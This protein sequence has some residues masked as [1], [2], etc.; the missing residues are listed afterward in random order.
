MN[1]GTINSK[2][3]LPIK[4]FAN[5]NHYFVLVNL[6]IA[7]W[8]LVPNAG[9]YEITLGW[10]PSTS[11]DVA[12][13]Y[14]HYGTSSREYTARIDAGLNATSVISGLQ[15]GLTYYFAATS[16]DH[17]GMQSKLSNEVS[18]FIPI[19]GQP[20]P[21]IT[22][23]RTPT[24]TRTPT[25]TAT[26]TDTPG[27]VDL[28][29]NL[30]GHWKL[31]EGTGLSAGD[32]SPWR[33]HGI[34]VN[35][36][37]WTRG[38]IH[39]GLSFDGIDDYVTFGNSTFNLTTQMSVCFWIGNVEPTDKSEQVILARGQY[40]YPFQIKYRNSNRTLSVTIRTNTN[41]YLY[42]SPLPQGTY[43]HV[44]VTYDGNQG[45]IYL[46][47][48]LD[49]VGT[50]T[51]ILG[52]GRETNVTT[53]GGWMA[54]NSFKGTIDDLRIYSRAINREEIQ[55][56]IRIANSGPTPLPTL[57]GISTPS[58]TP[59]RT[60]TPT[61]TA[62]PTSSP[63]TTPGSTATAGTTEDVLEGLV[64]HWRLDEG[65]GSTAQDS[66]SLR[67]H[68]TLVNGPQWTTG[69]IGGGLRFDGID[70]YVDLG[71][72]NLNLSSALSICFW[73]GNTR[74][75]ADSHQTLL[76]R[77][78]DAYPISIRLLYESRT[79]VAVIRT[80][81]VITLSSNPVSPFS[82][83]HVA[84]TYDG[85]QIRIYINGVLD[86]STGQTGKLH[87]GSSDY[88]TTLG[89]WMSQN[90]FKGVL[91]D[92][93][94][95]NRSLSSVEIQRLV[96]LANPTPTPTATVTPSP[97]PTPTV[98]NLFTGLV[99]HWELDEN[100]GVIAKDASPLENHGTLVNEPQWTVGKIGGRLRFDGIND[101][102]DLGDSTFDLSSQLSI[103]FWI[104]NVQQTTAPH[105][106]VLTRGADSYPFQ[107]RL[108]NDLRAVEVTVRTAETVK[109]TTGAL[110]P[111][112]SYHVAVIY[113]G[114][115]SKL[116]LNG[117]AASS[118]AQTGNLN[119][120][121]SNQRATLGGWMINNFFK[122]ILDDIRIYNRALSENEVQ[123][124]AALTLP[125]PTPSSTNLG[126]LSNTLT[127]QQADPLIE[128]RES[129]AIWKVLIG[130][131]VFQDRSVALDSL[132]QAEDSPLLVARSGQ[133]QELILL[134]WNLDP[135]PDDANR[136]QTAE[137]VLT[138]AEMK[139]DHPFNLQMRAL[140]H[141][142]PFLP[143]TTWTHFEGDQK[144]PR[145]SLAATAA[146]ESTVAVTPVSPED[147]EVR[148]DITQLVR[149]WISGTV[150]NQ[151]IVL[152][153]SASGYPVD[154]RFHSSES[155]DRRLRPR[156]EVRYW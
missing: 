118:M 106:V 74:M 44:A 91:D 36:P 20:T 6:F 47:G 108:S 137:L 111:F 115:L 99:G 39:G 40:V 34:L 70:D 24:S 128:T 1:R 101:Y 109:L 49:R 120:G 132:G 3:V 33:N 82:P 146:A 151:G 7:F 5:R 121:L 60:P 43:C 4:V 117:I 63:V 77:G 11:P 156:L 100:S 45:R 155:G 127:L 89:G 19:P 125:T 79:I 15:E 122:G 153:P 25:F 46:N 116:Y 76:T 124:L 30:S 86:S 27:S 31:D 61:R 92:V 90:S 129:E 18:Y 96:D 87:L 29:S 114:A 94:I 68:G 148:W 81:K 110:S 58:A 98:V 66:T 64:G 10:D 16:Y 53:L 69:R 42:S 17:L 107:V 113:D 62:T 85:S 55:E 72:M 93:R 57:T 22:P 119:L 21:T 136:I 56:L 48:V 152:T 140:T 8:F 80:S 83:S 23:T 97:T 88:I 144:W 32:A 126:T 73:L 9:A 51:G 13:Y 37:Q 135:L 138:V 103:C 28:F 141:V 112:L 84:I 50:L 59:T 75:T 154:I 139:S 149:S 35:G 123:Q 95:Y 145:G 2:S 12:G 14:I 150:E 54:D 102:V 78:P 41:L 104:G 71:K 130:P 38:K 147:N 142:K 65:S 105:Q 134:R 131:E 52:L 67:N 26:P 133:T 143:E